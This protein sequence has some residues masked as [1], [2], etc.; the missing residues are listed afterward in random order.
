MRWQVY[1]YD[2][3][4]KVSIEMIKHH[5]NRE[6]TL[7]NSLSALGHGKSVLLTITL[8]MAD[9]GRPNFY[10]VFTTSISARE[11]K[12]TPITSLLEIMLLW[13]RMYGLSE[14][15][16]SY[17]TNMSFVPYETQHTWAAEDHGLNYSLSPGVWQ[18]FVTIKSCNHLMRIISTYVDN[19]KKSEISW[20]WQLFKLGDNQLW[21]V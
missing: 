9:Q 3:Y 6:Q 5:S 4:C 16:S 11:L 17:L 2:I 20:R 18:S 1:K 12:Q 15:I 13:N 19:T 8:K 10:L 21:G 14:A 7:H